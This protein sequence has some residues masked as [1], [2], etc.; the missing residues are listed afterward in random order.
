[1]PIPGAP[2]SGKSNIVW[3]RTLADGSTVTTHET[4]ILARDSEGR[5][6]RER[7]DF[8]PMNVDPMSRWTEI[9]I[10]DTV[11]HTKTICS[12]YNRRCELTDYYP[13]KHFVV[14]QAGWNAQH[15]SFLERV[16]LGLDQ[17]QGVDVIGSRETT[18]L[19]TGVKGNDHP[20]VTTR[21]FWYNAAW[22][23]NLMV[24]RVDPMNGTQVV[25]LTE[26]SVGEPDADFFMVPDGYVV[27]DKRTQ[28]DVTIQIPAGSFG[29]AGKR[30]T[31]NGKDIPAATP[32]NSTTEQ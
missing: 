32:A 1:L 31:Y 21:E 22:Q 5:M 28:S 25:T 14:A 16:S 4:S 24:K 13:Q 17:M 6:Y 20:L 2:L 19:D 23:T 26:L 29:F 12:L 9:Q 15:T 10:Y 18:T 27:E 11:K 30:P 3:T 8:T 7:H